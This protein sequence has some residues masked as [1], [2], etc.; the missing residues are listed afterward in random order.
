MLSFPGLNP[1]EEVILHRRRHWLMLL[2][3]IAPPL[4]LIL[5][6][7]AAVVALTAGLPEW[8][9]GLSMGFLA[10]FIPLGI[11]LLWQAYDW[12]NDEFI[13]TNQRVIHIERVF[14]FSVDRR[15]AQLS[16]IQNVAVKI[17]NLIAN[18]FN[19]GNLIVE[20][21]GFEGKI[22]FDYIS[23]PKAVQAKI[24][25][26]RG[27]PLSTERPVRRASFYQSAFPFAPIR[28]D[29]IIT[30]HKHWFILLRAISLPLLTVVILVVLL[31]W[32]GT[33]PQIPIP[34]Q[35]AGSV[36]VVL[37]VLLIL[38]SLVFLWQ[39]VDWWND[40]Y[41]LTEDRIIDI[42]RIPLI[43]E[44][45]REAY[46]EQIQD[47]SYK[48]PNLLYRLLGLGDVFI[49]TAGK[50]ENFLFETVPNPA[51]V[52]REI[53]SR[54]AA[55][56]AQRQSEAIRAAMQKVFDERQPEM[57]N[58]ILEELQRQQAAQGQG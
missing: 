25:E 14:I 44:D 28:E 50:A 57:V 48:I 33:A 3:R 18:L 39:Y 32:I 20:T 21:A 11:W 36:Q 40:I 54:L 41:I 46:L 17:P 2:W 47:V 22:E 12:W 30:W 52:V 6:V 56:R 38:V 51:Q 35:Y 9:G 4:L 26:L 27:L 13:L 10:L 37:V 8:Q 58:T 1:G 24:L 49:E 5:A 29:A 31:V 7:L 34:E 45:R 42:S 19:V 15:E 55:V 53:S 43:F 16:R 23:D